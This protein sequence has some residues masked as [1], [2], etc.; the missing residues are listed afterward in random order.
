MA[1]AL[2]EPQVV[3]GLGADVGH[4][5]AITPD[6]H[7]S[8]IPPSRSRPLVRGSGRRKSCHHSPA[9]AS[10]QS[11]RAPRLRGRIGYPSWP[12]ETLSTAANE[13]AVAQSARPG[14]NRP[15]AS[16]FSRCA[17]MTTA[18]AG[19]SWEG[20]SSQTRSKRRARPLSSLELG[21]QPALA[22]QPV[23]QVLVDPGGRDPRSRD[24]DPGRASRGRR[25]GGAA[26]TRGRRP[27]SRRQGARSS[28]P[29][30]ARG[31]RRGPPSQAGS[32]RDRS[33]AP[34]WA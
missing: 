30:R 27:A 29:G 24:R 1:K 6:L 33:H 16:S 14:G 13:R 25:P 32:K 11:P 22:D 19:R 28:T 26:A 10:P 12:S 7:R 15:S 8:S 2:A 31:R 21:Q 18:A 3:P 5:P 23:L 17:C 34:A 20:T 4:S 9:A